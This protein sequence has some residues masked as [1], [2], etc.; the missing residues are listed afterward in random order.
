MGGFR[1]RIEKGETLGE[2]T[3]TSPGWLRLLGGCSRH[4]PHS[5]WWQMLTALGTPHLINPHGNLSAHEEAEPSHLP[6]ITQHRVCKADLN[7]G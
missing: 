5:E 4:S 2:T 6:R 7:L 1:N 3:L